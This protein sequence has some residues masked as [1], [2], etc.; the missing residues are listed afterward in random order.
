MLSETLIFRPI[1]LE[2]LRWVLV[3]KQD[4]ISAASKSDVAHAFLMR[5]QIQLLVVRSSPLV[6][7]SAVVSSNSAC[8]R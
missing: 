1:F 3:R 6:V 7:E 4:D 5:V 2:Q 8:R